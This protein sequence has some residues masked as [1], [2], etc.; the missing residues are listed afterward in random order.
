MDEAQ[1]DHLARSLG[2]RLS[3]RR[4]GGAAAGIFAVLGIEHVADAKKKKK[5]KKK[6]VDTGGGGGGNTCKKQCSNR[7]CGSDGCGGS[8]GSCGAN[9][10]CNSGTCESYTYVGYQSLQSL[11]Y[12]YAIVTDSS[13]VIYV[14]DGNGAVYIKPASGAATTFYTQGPAIWDMAT[15]NSNLYFTNNDTNKVR[16]YTMAGEYVSEWGTSGTAAGQL[17]GPAALAVGGGYALVQDWVGDNPRLQRFDAAT[18]NNPVQVAPPPGGLGPVENMFYS[19]GEFFVADDDAELIYRYSEGGTYLGTIGA[20]S[21]KG[22]LNGISGLTVDHKGQVIVSDAADNRVVVFKKTGEYVTEIEYVG[23]DWEPSVGI[24]T[25]EDRVYVLLQGELSYQ[26]SY[27]IYEAV[28]SASR[29][30]RAAKSP[31]RAKRHPQG[32]RQEK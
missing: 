20:S 25:F 6:K 4:L 23:Y 28:G 21:G 15:D 7:E 10:Q 3:R 16:R 8:C 12:A 1:I 31:R 2:S 32:G 29:E 30:G 19:G 11:Y 24:A 26:N 17:N 13:G 18:G 22:K 27:D 5:K 9:E 14:M